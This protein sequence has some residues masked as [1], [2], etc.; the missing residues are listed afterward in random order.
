MHLPPDDID[1]WIADLKDIRINSLKHTDF[2]VRNTAPYLDEAIKI[3]SDYIASREQEQFIPE[4]LPENFKIHRVA[5]KKRCKCPN[6]Y[7]WVNRRLKNGQPGFCRKNP[8][9]KKL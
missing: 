1:L 4:Q 3:L 5:T 9:R 8:K 6:G 2:Q 7:H